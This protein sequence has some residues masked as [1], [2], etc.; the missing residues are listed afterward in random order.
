[1][2]A[3]MLY[4]IFLI[5]SLDRYGDERAHDSKS[6]HDHDEEQKEKHYGVFQPDGF[7]ILAIR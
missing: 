3:P 2:F 4:D 7:E 5:V 6:C 1:M